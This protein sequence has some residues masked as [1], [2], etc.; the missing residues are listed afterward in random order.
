MLVS[1]HKACWHVVA[2][3]AHAPRVDKLLPSN[4]VSWEKP[5]FFFFS[6]NS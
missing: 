2:S 4:L 3:L 5:G 1:A 6:G